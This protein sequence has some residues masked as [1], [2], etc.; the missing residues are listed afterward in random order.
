M[1][2]RD[3]PRAPFK[4]PTRVPCVAAIQ[5]SRARATTVQGIGPGVR[6]HDEYRTLASRIL[7]LDF[8]WTVGLLTGG[9]SLPDR[10]CGWG[11]ELAD[12]LLVRVV[13][14]L[15]SHGQRQLTDVFCFLPPSLFVFRP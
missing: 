13:S 14:I 11:E 5:Y 8:G 2:S 6:A 10:R 3:E 9:L 15:H 4:L 1:S 7:F 12:C